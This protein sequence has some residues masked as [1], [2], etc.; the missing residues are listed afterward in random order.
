MVVQELMRGAM[1]IGG[2]TPDQDE[3]VAAFVMDLLDE[4]SGVGAR[5]C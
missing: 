1:R 5:V 3:S 4:F 2:R